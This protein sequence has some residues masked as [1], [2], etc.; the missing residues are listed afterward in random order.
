MHASL[1]SRVPFTDVRLCE[2]MSTLPPE[3]FLRRRRT[4]ATAEDAATVAAADGFE[5]KRVLRAAAFR[6]LPQPISDRRKRSF[7][8]PVFEWLTGAWAAGVSAKLERSAFARQLFR[9]EALC[10]LILQP[11]THG[12]LLWP[13]LNLVE[14]GDREFG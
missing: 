7:P 3:Q 6:R 9:T 4:A 12:L 2:A 11:A 5:T 1:E 10:D 13:V 14:W 8:T